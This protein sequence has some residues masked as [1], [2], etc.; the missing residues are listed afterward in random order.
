MSKIHVEKCG[1]KRFTKKINCNKIFI[2]VYFF[3]YFFI[4]K[5]PNKQKYITKGGEFY[6]CLVI[7]K[8]I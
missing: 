2:I 4:L 5:I 6:E 3:Q 1:E 8:E 7:I